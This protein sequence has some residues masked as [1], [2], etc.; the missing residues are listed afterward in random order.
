MQFFKTF[1]NLLYEQD[2]DPPVKDPSEDALEILQKGLF[3]FVS[4]TLGERDSTWI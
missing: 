1:Q 2:E 4:L 3:Y